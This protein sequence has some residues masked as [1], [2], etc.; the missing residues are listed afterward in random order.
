[1]A[2]GRGPKA[3]GSAFERECVKAAQYHGLEAKRAWGSNGEALGLTSD[4]DCVIGKLTAQ[5]KRRKRLPD[6]LVPPE[7]VDLVLTRADNGP[8]LVIMRFEQ[9]LEGKGG[10]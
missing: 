9:F 8:A 7:G 6:Y 5:C 2:G 4:V 10:R 1:M 3:K